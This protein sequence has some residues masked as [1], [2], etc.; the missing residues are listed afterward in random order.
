MAFNVNGHEYSYTSLRSSV[1][2]LRGD[3]LSSIDYDDDLD[4]GVIKDSDGIP[5]GA[6]KGEYTPSCSIEFHTRRHFQEFLDS[7][8][9]APYE[10]FFTLTVSYSETNV[11]PVLTDTIPRCRIKKPSV[12]AAKGSNEAIP[13]KVELLVAGV[14]L[15]NGVANVSRRS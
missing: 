8:G 15:W 10:Q 2:T 6:T 1:G 12:S 7:L 14:I 4:G 11:T 9:T 5:V 3:Y 13:I